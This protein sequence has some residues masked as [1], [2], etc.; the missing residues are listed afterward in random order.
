[1]R[2]LKTPAVIIAFDHGFEHGPQSYPDVDM[3]PKRIAKIALKG[4]A[5]ALMMN[6]GSWEIVGNTGKLVRIVKLTGK[7]SLS[8]R[9][10]QEM[11]TTVADAM[12]YKPDV[13]A[14]TVYPGSNDEQHMLRLAAYI[15]EEAHKRKLPVLGIV[16]PRTPTRYNERDVMYAARIGS[17]IG[18]D[19]IKT[20]H[21]KNSGFANVV[22]AAFKP[23][24]ASGGKLEHRDV[25]LQTVEEVMKSGAAGVAV[26]RN[27]WARDDAVSFLK[28]VVRIVKKKR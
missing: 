15:K 27:V 7:S 1:M 28:K 3:D 24:F 13:F 17:E 6:S 12:R 26:G 25:Y 11:H 21:P 10:M 19:F 18:F 2:K 20:Y 4:G 9:E 8:K 5:D 22:K 14:C 16:Y 23:V